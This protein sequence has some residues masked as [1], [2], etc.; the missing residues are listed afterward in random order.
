MGHTRYTFS[1]GCIVLY[2]PLGK[3]QEP[4]CLFRPEMHLERRTNHS[5]PFEYHVPKMGRPSSTLLFKTFAKSK[6]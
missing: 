3:G 6:E 4:T 5:H 1:T 2:L